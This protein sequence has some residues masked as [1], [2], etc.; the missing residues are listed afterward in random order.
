MPRA[1]KIVMDPF[2]SQA[3]K[4]FI[5]NGVDNYNIA[6]T[7]HAPYYPIGFYAIDSDNSVLGGLMGQIWAHWLHVGTLWVDERVR[8]R[9]LATSL[10]AAAE[11]YAIAKGCTNAFLETFSFQA[12]PFYEKLGYKVFGTLEG[13]PEGHRQFYMSKRLGRSSRR[14][15]R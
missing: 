13:Y 1:P 15:A 4:D 12:R 3:T 6:V 9:G 10:M 5:Q 7:G 14:R 11:R 8:R 2:A